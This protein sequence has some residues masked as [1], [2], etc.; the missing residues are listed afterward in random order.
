MLY[1]MVFDAVLEG[2]AGLGVWLGLKG[3][4]IVRA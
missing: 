4:R 2:L 3:Q 1:C